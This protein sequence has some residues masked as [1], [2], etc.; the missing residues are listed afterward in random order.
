L[1]G[2]VGQVHNDIVSA[3]S[4]VF[5]LYYLFKGEYTNIGKHLYKLRVLIDRDLLIVWD[6]AVVTFI[7]KMPKRAEGVVVVQTSILVNHIEL[8]V[9]A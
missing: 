3:E 6:E 7:R 4:G 1:G 5:R 9:P 8:E 2:Q